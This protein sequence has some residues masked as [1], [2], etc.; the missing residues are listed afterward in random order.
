MHNTIYIRLKASA[1]LESIQWTVHFV[2]E[3]HVKIYT[4]LKAS[5]PFRKHQLD[6]TFLKW[7]SKIR[8]IS[9]GRFC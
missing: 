8:Y 9:D 2:M 3:R 1:T 4:G 6:R 7:N 5:E